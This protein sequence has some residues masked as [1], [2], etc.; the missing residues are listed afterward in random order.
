MTNEIPDDTIEGKPVT[1]LEK[2]E[3]V[4]SP[5]CVICEF[6]MSQINNELKDRTNEVIFYPNV[7][8]LVF[9]SE[10]KVFFSRNILNKLFI[11]YATIYRRQFRMIVMTLLINTQM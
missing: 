1:K 10:K 9:F 5:Q 11:V 2:I 8:K 3:K 6:I 7:I 4:G